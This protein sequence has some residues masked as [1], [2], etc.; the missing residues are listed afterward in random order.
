MEWIVPPQESGVKLLAFLQ[1]KLKISSKQIKRGLDKGYCQINGRVERFGSTVLGKSDRIVLQ[2]LSESSSNTLSFDSQRILY[3]DEEILVYNKPAGLI[4]DSK[5]VLKIFRGNYPTLQL[6]HRLDRDTTGVLLLAKNEAALA[7]MEGL[8]RNKMI[9]KTYL[10][11]VDGVPVKNEGTIESD[12]GKL[13]TFDGQTVWG[14]VGKGKG[15]H[16]VTQWK[17]IATGPDTALIQCFSKTGRTH[18]IRVH[19]SEL[20]HPLLGDFQYAKKFRSKYHPQRYL[21]HA[22]EVSFEHPLKKTKI[23]IETPLPQDFIVAYKSLFK[24]F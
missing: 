1:S 5:S 6:I 3:E 19:L 11:I 22:S 12:L 24:I 21:L 20:G 4:S 9:Q 7:M 10:A 8:F 23:Q 16:S 2:N 17:K 15:L 18:Q 13:Y 14:S